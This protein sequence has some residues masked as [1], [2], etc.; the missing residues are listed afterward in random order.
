MGTLRHLQKLTAAAAA[1]SA[2]ALLASPAFAGAGDPYVPS[3]NPWLSINVGSASGTDLL[4]PSTANDGSNNFSFEGG[5]TVTGQYA[6]NWDLL[7]NPDPFIDGS[8]TIT[9]LSNFAQNFTVN[10]SVPVTPA[11]SNGLMSG[12]INATVFDANNS[13]AATLQ[14]QTTNIYFG[15]IDDANAL[16][17]F[18][19]SLTCSGS[20]GCSISSSDAQTSIPVGGVNTK[21]GTRLV[22]NLSAND[23]VTF[24]THFE[25]MPVPVP[26]SAWLMGSAI[27]GLFGIS[28]RK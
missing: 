8:V 2:F 27:L 3:L 13:G 14:P 10:L 12:S 1:V 18:A 22:F 9:N 4:P 19:Q 23:K 24:S 15:R 26:A 21:I 25:V 17:L 5:G 28:R 16:S 20:A 6:V 7:M 11:F